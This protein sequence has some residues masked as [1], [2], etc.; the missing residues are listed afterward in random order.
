MTIRILTFMYHLLKLFG[1][2]IQTSNQYHKI[3]LQE[4][5]KLQFL[6]DPGFQCFDQ[7]IPNQI[8]STLKKITKSNQD[9]V[10]MNARL[11]NF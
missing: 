7:R 1:L 11:V 8:N 10:N 5:S 3:F 6:I 9:Q 4:I 2:E